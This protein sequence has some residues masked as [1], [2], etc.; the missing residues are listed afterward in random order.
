MIVEHL[1]KMR[2]GIPY[3][4]SQFTEDKW[5]EWSSKQSTIIHPDISERMPKTNAILWTT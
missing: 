2:H 1:H 5:T 3:T 4:E